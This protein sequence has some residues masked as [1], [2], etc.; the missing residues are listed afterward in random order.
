[1]KII[2]HVTIIRPNSLFDEHL[3]N[4]VESNLLYKFDSTVKF[5]F[6]QNLI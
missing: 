5:D 6:V 1:M 2:V 4:L 3:T